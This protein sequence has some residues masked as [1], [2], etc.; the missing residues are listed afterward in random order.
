MCNLS[1]RCRCRQT[2]VLTF[3]WRSDGDG[4][5]CELLV[6]V[7]CVRLRGDLRLERRDQLQETGSGQGEFTVFCWREAR[8]VQTE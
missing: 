3:L 8:V 2:G 7:A 1:A 5:C 4:L 6:K